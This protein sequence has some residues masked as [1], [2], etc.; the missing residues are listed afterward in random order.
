MT[1]EASFRPTNLM[2]LIN[3]AWEKSF[4]RIHQNK[5]AIVERG[6]NP[7]NYNLLTEPDLR[8]TMTIGE[9]IS[10]HNKI[11]LPPSMEPANNSDSNHASFANSA[12]TTPHSSQETINSRQSLLN[13]ATGVTAECL[14]VLVRSE[15]LMEARERI[16]KDKANGKD[17]ETR[18]K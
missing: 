4:A 3:I 18:L 2:P 5:K 1:H 12:T 10:E 9:K 8:A 6:W 14:T 13:F 7:L 15:Q 17:L 11:I 16:R